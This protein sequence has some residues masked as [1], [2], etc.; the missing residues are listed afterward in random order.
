MHLI[1]VRHAEGRASGDPDALRPLTPVGR[2]AAALLGELLAGARPER[3]RLEPAAP[4]AG[5]GRGDRGGLR[6]RRDW[7]SERLAPGSTVERL[8]EAVAGRGET[9]IAVGHQP[10]FGQIALALSGREHAFPTAGYAE[11]EL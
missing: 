6:A 3:G 1:L 2:A 5:D 7:S 8:R 9:V 11:L 10:D 4:G